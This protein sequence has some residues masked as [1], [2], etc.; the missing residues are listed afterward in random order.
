MPC[1][2]TST[3]EG[4]QV[5]QCTDE[6]LHFSA[7]D[8]DVTST[9][10]LSN[11]FHL[12]LVYDDFGYK[13]C[14]S[15]SDEEEAPLSS[16]EKLSAWAIAFN[17][18]NA[19]FA[20]LLDILR[21]QHPDFPKDPRTLRSIPRNIELKSV[22]GSQYFHLGLKKGIISKL[23]LISQH[24]PEE[25]RRLKQLS[26]QFNVDGLPLFKSVPGEFWPIL[27]LIENVSCKIPFAVGVYYGKQKPTN[28]DEYFT[29]F[30][31]EIQEILGEGIECCGVMFSIKISCFVCDAPARAFIKNITHHSGYS[32]CERCTSKGCWAGKIIHTDL[33]A[34][35]R[36]NSSFCSME[37][38]QHHKDSSPLASLDVDMI[39]SFPLDSM[40]LCCLGIMR[41]ML[42]LWFRSLE[43]CRINSGIYSSIC[44]HLISL[45]SYCPREFTRQP[46]SLKYL[47]RWKAT[48]LWQFILY[49]GT[50]VLKDKISKEIILNIF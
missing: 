8:G 44:S 17:V 49:I 7:I 47:E 39:K 37:D 42:F 18:S 19:S 32:S 6:T 35:L 10:E 22:A 30:I 28:A 41:R 31:S 27:C 11:L 14:V 50:V 36:T 33:Y 2:N 12:G 16:T 1:D 29:A 38:E 25:F 26:L 20:S 23:M 40:H 48:E 43:P 24:Q 13:N 5:K 9:N 21:D 4:Q 3:I 46:R 15:S 34:T 45:S